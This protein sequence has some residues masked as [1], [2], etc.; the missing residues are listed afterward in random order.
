MFQCIR[1]NDFVT[2]PPHKNTGI[3]MRT[4]IGFIR[5]L[6][7]NK[8]Q[9][10]G[11]P[12]NMALFFLVSVIFIHWCMSFFIHYIKNIYYHTNFHLCDTFSKNITLLIQNVCFPM[13][14]RLKLYSKDKNFF[15]RKLRIRLSH[16]N[17]TMRLRLIASHNTKRLPELWK[18]VFV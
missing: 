13:P 14:C 7:N 8:H 6:I 5:Y 18:N 3:S 12:E 16:A 17:G 10:Y 15:V 9:T 4:K 1:I 11:W 2:F